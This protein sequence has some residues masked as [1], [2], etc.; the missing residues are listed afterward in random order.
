MYRHGLKRMIDFI[1]VFMALLIVGPILLF[2]TL[3]LHFANKGEGAFFTQKRPGKNGIFFRVIKFKTMTD[4][5]D[6]DGNLLPDEQRLTKVGKFIR[7]TSIDE[8]PQLINVFKGDMALVGPRPLLTQ[9]L[10]LY[11]KEQMR[12]HEVRPGITGWAQVNGRN[13]ISWT[14]KFE[15]DVWY[16]NNLSFCLDLKIFFLT[17]KKVF[18]RV[19]INSANDVTME[20]FDGTN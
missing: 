18:Y 5:C 6:E 8:L 16:V 12:R 10:P 4:K 19:D 9:Y 14:K 3:W 17:I 20:D 11:N 2:I 15:L 13:A 7:S 1:F